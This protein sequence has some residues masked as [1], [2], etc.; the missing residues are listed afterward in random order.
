MTKIR[1]FRAAF[2]YLAQ[3][4]ITAREVLHLGWLDFKYFYTLKR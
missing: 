3:S 1:R 2:V 4:I